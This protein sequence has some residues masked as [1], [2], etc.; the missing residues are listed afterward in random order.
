M[1]YHAP[2]SFRIHVI[3]DGPDSPLLD[4]IKSS[5]PDGLMMVSENGT[6]SINH[7]WPL[8]DS[9]DGDFLYFLEDDYLHVPEADEIFFEGADK[10]PL[11]TLYDHPDRYTRTDDITAGKDLL[12]ITKSCHWRTAESTTSTWACSRELWPHISAWAKQC[13]CHDR[14]F[15]QELV[16]RGTR[17]WTPIPGKATHSRSDFP[18][19]MVDWENISNGVTL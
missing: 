5:K 8:A 14:L 13:G 19:P 18:S 2:Q 16:R 17:L 15:F 4:Y 1:K 6:A 3:W 9:L 12:K 7:Q 10:F 11:F